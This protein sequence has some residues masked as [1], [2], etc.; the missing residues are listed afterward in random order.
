MTT[1]YKG[2]KLSDLVKDYVPGTVTTSIA[3]ALT[4]KERLESNKT[5]GVHR[6]MRKGPSAVIQIEV[7]GEIHDHSEFQKE[8]VAEHSRVNCWTSV[9]KTK[10][11]INSVVSWRIL[12]LDEIERLLSQTKSTIYKTS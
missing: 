3:E 5:K 4:W 1:F 12:T 6:E 2:V 11:Q 7:T 8:G 9:A 10:A